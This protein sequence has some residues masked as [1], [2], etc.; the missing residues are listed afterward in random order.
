MASKLFKFFRKDS[1]FE[2]NEPH[3]SKEDVQH[4][5]LY[6]KELQVGEL[7]CENG[8]WIFKYAP[9]F[10][11]QNDK[12]HLIVGFPDLH[13]EYRSEILWPFFQIRIPG[14]G[15]PAIRE[16]IERENLDINNEVQLLKRFGKKTLA[17]PFLLT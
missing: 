15:Q 11:D 6:L 12:Y 3:L 10:I 14:L 17:N 2:K 5:K 13:K 4:F 7:S 8:E 9:E 1:F 16:I